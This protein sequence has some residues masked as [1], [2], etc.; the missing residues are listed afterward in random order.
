M[1]EFVEGRLASRGP[2]RVVVDVGG[3]GYEISVPL[4]SV[5]EPVGK[6]ADKNRDGSERVRVWTHLIVREDSQRL[7]GFS[8]ARTREVFRLLLQVR[9]V[10]PGMAQAI[11]STLP[12]ETL[13]EAVIAEDT[14]A[15][16][17]IKGVGKKTAEQILLDLRDRAPKLAQTDA[18]VVVPQ[19]AGSSQVQADA[20]HALVSVGFS[21]KEAQKSVERAS[22][23]VDAD[24]LELLVRTAL[25]G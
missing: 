8:D 1:Y 17:R 21:E 24:D 16:T 7:F 5:F 20:V 3:I 9:G 15:F 13:L 18:G 10:G 12:G 2:T 6:P 14:V 11:L 23:T 25:Q 22:K 19:A 4:G